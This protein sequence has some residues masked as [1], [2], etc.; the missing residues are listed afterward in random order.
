[1]PLVNPVTVTGE[2]TPVAVIAPGFE[3]TLYPVI[4]VPP[5]LAGGVN[6]TAAL[7]LPAVA[8]PM[9][10]APGAENVIVGTRLPVVLLLPSWPVLL[11]PQHC[12]P[13]LT[14]AQLWASPA[15]TAVTLLPA[16]IAC[17]GVRLVAVLLLPSQPLPLLPQHC[18]P[19]LTTA[20]LWVK[21]A[22]IAVATGCAL[23]MG[24]AASSTSDVTIARRDF[25]SADGLS[26]FV[27]YFF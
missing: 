6:D 23:A 8:V 14:I 3:V 17:T 1:M 5:L 21:P 13:P 18:T 10:G 16:A 24:A 12:T 27:T 7:P 20:Q 9:V 22:A 26:I 19:P 11:L 2:L 25:M 4:D 15:A